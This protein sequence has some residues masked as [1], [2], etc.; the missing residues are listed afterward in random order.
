MLKSL[1]QS[2]SCKYE[3]KYVSDEAKDG[4]VWSISYNANPPQNTYVLW[5]DNLDYLLDVMEEEDC[6]E[7]IE[8]IQ[9]PPFMCG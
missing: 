6:A 9:I 4:I 3:I 2:L 5:R 1:N 8:R 7:P